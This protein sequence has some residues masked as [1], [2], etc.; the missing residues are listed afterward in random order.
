MRIL[1][2]VLTK[3]E[4]TGRIDA[5]SVVL[6]LPLDSSPFQITDAVKRKA[7]SFCNMHHQFHSLSH[8]ILP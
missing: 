7:D 4:A 6:D 2:T 3:S 1:L 5:D 8:T